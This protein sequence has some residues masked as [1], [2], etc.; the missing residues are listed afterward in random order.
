MV[1]RNLQTVS[2]EKVREATGQGRDHWFSL[3]DAAGATSWK[4]PRIAKH[5]TDQG[6]SAWWSQSLTVAYEQERGLRLPGQR[7]DRTFEANAS[8]TLRTTRSRLWPLLADDVAREAWL[9]VAL[10]VAGQTEGRTLRLAG[11]DASRVTFRLDWLDDD[12]SSPTTPPRVRVSVQHSNL[13]N[14]GTADAA[15]ARWSAALGRLAQA[16]EAAAAQA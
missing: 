11:P 15:K 7:P 5:L 6:V 3:L 12:A 4:H 1:R 16:A 14:H 10:P 8:K 13:A 2:D 9:G